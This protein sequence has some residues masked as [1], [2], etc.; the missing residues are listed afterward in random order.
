MHASALGGGGGGG[1]NGSGSG[2][3]GSGGGSGGGGARS[4]CFG[5]AR[6]AGLAPA[7]VEALAAADPW[8]RWELGRRLW[9]GQ[10]PRAAAVARAALWEERW[11]DFDDGEEDE[12]EG[13]GGSGGGG[14]AAAA[15]RLAAAARARAAARRRRT[16]CMLVV[17][18]A[19]DLPCLWRRLEAV[20]GGAAATAAAD[21]RAAARPLITVVGEQ[22]AAGKEQQQQQEKQQQQGE[23]Q[24]QQQGAQQQQDKQQQD[25]Q[26]QQ[27]GE[28]QEQ[29]Q[30]VDAAAVVGSAPRPPAIDSAADGSDWD[31][32]LAWAPAQRLRALLPLLRALRGAVIAPVL[33]PPAELWVS[34]ARAAAQRRRWRQGG[35][36]ERALVMAAAD[37]AG[38]AVGPRGC[39][40]SGPEL[41]YAGVPPLLTDACSERLRAHAAAAAA[42]AGADAAAAAWAR[43]RDD[44]AALAAA[45]AEEAEG[46]GGAHGATPPPFRPPLPPLQY[47]A[48][49]RA[50]ASGG[51]GAGSLAAALPLAQPPP[52]PALPRPLWDAFGWAPASTSYSLAKALADGGKLLVLDQLLARLKA[53]GHRVLLF[54]QVRC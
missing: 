12:K 4:G 33:A 1:S 29:P 13:G 18:L 37:G 52:P 7:E 31:R 8:Q 54:C 6:L 21:E 41:A 25:K 50:A 51:A 19:S 27:P 36:W 47:Y 53:E 28:Q 3:S 2:G 48:R 46:G 16:R 30:M 32:P 44:A 10:A 17:P 38:W 35:A 40:A 11:R 9:R 22:P 20:K 49:A 15:R 34:D 45:A 5:F 39:G 24:Q 14:R 23:Q 43:A 42:E 26:Q